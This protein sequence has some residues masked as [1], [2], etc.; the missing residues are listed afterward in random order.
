MPNETERTK[1]ERSFASH[2]LIW[3]ALLF[4]L[5]ALYV[6]SIGPA[7]KLVWTPGANKTAGVRIMQNFYAPLSW[8]C[9]N[10]TCAK[11]FVTWYI[12]QVWGIR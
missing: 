4:G 12:Q 7:L 10:N 11:D 6:L 5:V 8:V 9:E 2:L 1:T 3:V